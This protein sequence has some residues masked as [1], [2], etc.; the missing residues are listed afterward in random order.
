MRVNGSVSIW[1]EGECAAK[2]TGEIQLTDYGI[3]GIPVFQVSRYAS[4]LLYEK[5]R[6]NSDSGFYAGLYRRTD[7]SVL[8]LKGE[9]AA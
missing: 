2:D 7:R 4:K 5:K 9:D 1:S 3:S 6:S 8:K